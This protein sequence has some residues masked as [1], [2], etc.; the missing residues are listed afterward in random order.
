MTRILF[1][2]STRVGDAVLSTGLLGR[3]LEDHPG[4]RVTVVCGPAA[5]SLFEAVPGLERIIPLHKMVLSFHWTALWFSLV[6]CWWDVIVDLRRSPL[7][8]VLPGRRR[9]RLGGNGDDVH[10]VVHLARVLDQA[11]NPPAPRLWLDAARQERAARAIPDGA[12]VLAVAPTANWR[13]KTWRADNFAALIEALTGPGGI[14]ADGRVAVFGAAEERPQAVSLIDSIPAA[15]RIDLFGRLD[16]LDVYACLRRCALY[17]GND[18]GLMHIAAAAGIPTLGL[19]GPTREDLYAPWGPRGA[20]VRTPETLDQIFPPD[21]DHRRSDTLMDSLTVEA[22]AAA[23]G[24]LWRR[25]AV[26]A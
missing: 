18:S 12:P 16:L 9:L 25:T 6:G 20:V 17:V 3:L 10:R 24:A 23:A 1:I 4:A 2:T 7:S 15:R 21:F 22:A 26:A 19:F 13:A 14:L 8:Y 11:D 5:T